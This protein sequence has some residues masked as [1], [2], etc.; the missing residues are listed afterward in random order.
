M[1]NLTSAV[2]SGLERL[3]ARLR[4]DRGFNLVEVLTV[5]VILGAIVAIAVA[6]YGNHKEKAHLLALKSDTRLIAQSFEMVYAEQNAY[7]TVVAPTVDANGGAAIEL[8]N[9]SLDAYVPIYS[10]PV[11]RGVT[12][13]A[14]ELLPGGEAFT[15]T[16]TSSE[17]ANRSITWDST[18]GGFTG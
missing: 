10:V 8:A 1:S 13:T 5:T 12:V 18:I 11:T 2:M 9:G 17:N 6:Q 7:P 14:V 15:V 16:M 3:R 4:D